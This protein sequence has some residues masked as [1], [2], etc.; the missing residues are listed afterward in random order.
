MA[1][2]PEGRTALSSITLNVNH[3]ALSLLRLPLAPL[4]LVWGLV[5]WGRGKLFDRGLLPSRCFDV[6]VICVG[7]LAVGGTG[8][9]PHVEHILRLLHDRGR[10]VAMLSRGYGR[11]SKGFVLCRP[12][13]TAEMIGDEPWQISR[14]CPWAVVAVCERRVEGIER[15][16]ALPEPPEVI[17]LD[18]AYQHRYVRAGL[19]VLLTE[20]SRLYTHDHLLPWGRLREP[21]SAAR[22]AD[23]VVV[24]KCRDEADRPSLPLRPGQ[25]LYYSRIA[26]GRPYP[27]ADVSRRAMAAGAALPVPGEAEGHEDASQ[28]FRPQAVLVIAGIAHPWPLVDHLRACGAAEVE[29]CAFPDHHAFCPRDLRRM[30]EAWD[31]LHRTA[32]PEAIALTTQ[33]DAARLA[34]LLS[35]LS[36]DLQR[37]LY[38]IPITV[39]IE[40]AAG[41]TQSFNQTILS[42]VDQD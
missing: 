28:T 21:A 32:R 15:L 13:V 23:V 5:A 9:T 8:K 27:L 42:Y 18:D 19:N 40:P 16:L 33:K 29:L 39:A 6:P 11:R 14:N 2:R 31:R 25:R 20:A 35:Q 37:N 3:Y 4:S 12:G 10:R 1:V 41:E 36:P 24:T 7:N 26:Y 34:P 38:V 30:E 22:R 17:V